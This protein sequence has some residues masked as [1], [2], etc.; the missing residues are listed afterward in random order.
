MI[1]CETGVRTGLRPQ[2]EIKPAQQ[3]LDRKNYFLPRFRGISDFAAVPPIVAKA[4]C[5]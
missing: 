1:L 2:A 3:R 4:K 5:W